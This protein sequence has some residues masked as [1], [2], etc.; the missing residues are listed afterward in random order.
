VIKREKSRAESTRGNFSPSR[1][2]RTFLHLPYSCAL[3]CGPRMLLTQG[4]L[5]SPA[6]DPDAENLRVG[7]GGGKG[8]LR[9]RLP[10]DG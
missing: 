7:I 9:P 5:A 10:G 8:G 2:P 3:P 1:T 6:S 4:S